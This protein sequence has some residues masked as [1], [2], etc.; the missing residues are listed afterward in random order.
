MW[1]DTPLSY[2]ASDSMTRTTAFAAER[3]L[4]PPNFQNVISPLVIV[5]LLSNCIQR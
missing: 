4:Y 5:R 1:V 3:H 2:V